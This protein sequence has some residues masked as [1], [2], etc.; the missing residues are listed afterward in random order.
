MTLA[1]ADLAFAPL[2]PDPASLGL[3]PFSEIPRLVQAP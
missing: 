1:V 2:P 3:H